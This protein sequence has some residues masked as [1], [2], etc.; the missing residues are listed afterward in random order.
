MH[1]PLRG[2]HMSRFP[3][4]HSFLLPQLRWR[5]KYYLVHSLSSSIRAWS[6]EEASG[7]FLA[8]FLAQRKPKNAAGCRVY[9]DKVGFG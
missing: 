1:M 8:A 3:P 6:A 4:R 5:K 2:A 7:L 9:T